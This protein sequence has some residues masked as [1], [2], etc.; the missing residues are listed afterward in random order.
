M[1]THNSRN[2]LYV[3]ITEQNEAGQWIGRVIDDHRG[4]IR[5]YIQSNQDVVREYSTLSA[6]E[7]EDDLF[8]QFPH[9]SNAIR[10][11]IESNTPTLGTKDFEFSWDAQGAQPLTVVMPEMEA[12]MDE[13]YQGDDG[14]LGPATLFPRVSAVPRLEVGDLLRINHAVGWSPE[15]GMP[16]QEHVQIKIHGLGILGTNVEMKD[17]GRYLLW[18]LIRLNAESG[19]ASLV[20][21]GRLV[22]PKSGSMLVEQ[23]QADRKLREP[24][25]A[26]SMGYA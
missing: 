6:R 25:K 3:L 1:T 23:A 19:Y 15:D 24:A 4:Q 26:M 18:D 12:Q 14:K 22:E 9:P 13:I 10:Q 2:P 5:G 21:P 16:N 8:E 7:N 17:V 20:S 11:E